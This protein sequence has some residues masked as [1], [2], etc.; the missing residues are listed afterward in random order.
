MDYV[1]SF[2]LNMIFCPIVCLYNVFE[3]LGHNILMVDKTFKVKEIKE[4]NILFV[5]ILDR[6]PFSNFQ[7]GKIHFDISIDVF[8]D[9]YLIILSVEKKFKMLL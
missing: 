5:I 7:N 2:V 9:Q 1:S 4:R 6:I 8:Q 3:T